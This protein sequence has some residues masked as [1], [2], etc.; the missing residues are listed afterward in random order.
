MVVE[1][2]SVGAVGTEG[3]L[4]C[5][6]ISAQGRQYSNKYKDVEKCHQAKAQKHSLPPRISGTSEFLQDRQCIVAKGVA[7]GCE[8]RA[9]LTTTVSGSLS[10]AFSDET[11]S[12]LL[13]F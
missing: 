6:S 3:G 7:L 8:G 13:L 10:F 9:R 1:T 11:T 12:F 2:G 4:F 5:F